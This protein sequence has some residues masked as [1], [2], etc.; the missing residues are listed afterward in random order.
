MLIVKLN[1][2]EEENIL[3]GFPWVYNNEVHS[4]N[5]DIQNG[6]VVQVNTFDDNFVGYGFLN[7]SSKLMV[8]M[9]SLNKEDHIDKEFFR[10][11]IRYALE[12]RKNLNLGNAQRLIFA[13]ADFL[14]G[15][16]VDQYNDI[17][18]V[19]F[20][21]LGMEKIKK[22]I[23][24]ILIDEISPR[25][26]YE[27]SDTPIRIKEGLEETKGIL[28]GDFDP[29]VEVIENGIRFIVDVEHG[30]KTGYFLDQ[31]LNRDM[32]KYYVQDKVVLD[33][34]SNVGGFALH[35]CKYNAKHVDACD[36]SKL[37]CGEIEANAKLNGFQ[38]L[39]VICTDVFDYL[40]KEELKNK[41]DI[42][43]LD[44]PAFTKDK[45]TVKK[46]YRGYKEINLQALKIIKSGGYLLT[47]SCS[48]HMTPDLFLEML[49]EAAVDAKREVQFLDFKIQAPDHP[50]LL[51]GKEQLYLKCIVLR[52]K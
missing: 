11:K 49:K 31:K 33:C 35:A 39:N 22:D 41:Y 48:Q 36:I 1:P 24:D 4:F 20:L 40:R 43:I 47:F 6:E 15:L 25:G 23:I 3:K 52:V 42:I 27:R 44:P 21:C 34:F 45:T 30:Q 38:Q 5:G 28:Y 16:I 18:S 19:Q 26:I 32:V 37:A 12:H 46:A 14:P 9:L 10:G 29:R 8:R 51:S 17:L 13:E 50:A 2:K 7:V